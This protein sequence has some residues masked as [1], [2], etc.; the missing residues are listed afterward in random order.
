M[1]LVDAGFGLRWNVCKRVI[2]LQYVMSSSVG[3]AD[4]CCCCAGQPS[5]GKRGGEQ[6]GCCYNQAKP[7]LWRYDLRMDRCLIFLKKKNVEYC[8]MKLLFALM[9]SLTFEM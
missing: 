1:F 7:L 6:G 9:W 8:E 2:R 5:G 4:K 3:V